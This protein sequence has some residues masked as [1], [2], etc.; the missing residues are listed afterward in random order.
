MRESSKNYAA[1]SFILSWHQQKHIYKSGITTWHLFGE[2]DCNKK[3]VF[4]LFLCWFPL[5]YTAFTLHLP[6]F[7]LHFTLNVRISGKVLTSELIDRG[8]NSE[9]SNLFC[10]AKNDVSSV[11]ENSKN[12]ANALTEREIDF[13]IFFG[14]YISVTRYGPTCSVRRTNADSEI[15]FGLFRDSI[16]SFQFE[17]AQNRVLR[18]KEGSAGT[19]C[20]D[21]FERL[22][23]RNAKKRNA[24]YTDEMKPSYDLGRRRNPCPAGPI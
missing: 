1:K 12:T 14:H 7:A 2:A 21:L 11:P 24:S 16:F 3:H 10:I 18:M 13:M 23:W 8:E 9:F 5:V 22:F 19:L 6:Y 15:Q 4:S 20:W 17:T